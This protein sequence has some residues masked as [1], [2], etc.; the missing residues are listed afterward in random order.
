MNHDEDY[1]NNFLKAIKKDNPLIRELVR[2]MYLSSRSEKDKKETIDPYMRGVC[3]V[4]K[5]IE[6]Q[7]EADE[8]NKIWGDD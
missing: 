1:F 4:Y 5:L 3:T 6:S 7:M 8:M 2:V